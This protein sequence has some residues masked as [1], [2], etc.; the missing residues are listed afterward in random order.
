MNGRHMNDT[1]WLAAL[2]HELALRG[3]DAGARAEAVLEAEAHLAD[4]DAGAAA[5]ELFGPADRYADDLARAAGTPGRRPPP[6]HIDE[7]WLLQAQGVARAYRGRPA[8]SPTSLTVTAGQVVALV[9]P[10]GAGKSTLLRLL[11]GLEPPDR[12]TVSRRAAAGWVPQN[13]GLDPYLRP[14]E[15]VELFGVARGLSRADARK[16]GE[17]LARQLGWGLAG[18]PVAG[19]LSGGT[20]QKLRMV[21]ALVGSPHLI[22]ADEPY[23]GLDAD[24]TRR[25]WE[26]LWSVCEDGAGAVVSSH[27]PEVLRRADTVLELQPAGHQPR[28]A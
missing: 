6:A 24:S 14:V 19:R 28:G 26:L 2:D 17:R 16:Q 7:A 27:D 25:F 1:D 10:N 13:G 21:L 15:H 12:G 9:G 8:L 23:Q 4:S 3:M 22:L 18:T 11:A 5:H 20:A